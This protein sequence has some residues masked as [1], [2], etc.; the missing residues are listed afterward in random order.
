MAAMEG[1]PFGSGVIIGIISLAALLFT[2][3]RL[4]QKK[5][6]YPLPPGPR[7]EPILGH[8]RTVPVERPEL[9]YEQLAKEYSE[10]LSL[11]PS[12]PQDTNHTFFADTDIL[13]FRQLRTPV[14]VLNTV[15]AAEEL[16]SKRGANFSDRPRFVLFEV[17][18][19][20]GVEITQQ[21]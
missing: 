18:V 7:G 12:E 21:G 11:P 3:A 4:I 10:C 6:P 16:L 8:I 5:S 15:K 2:A 20:P 19:E 13:Y 14:I 17:F 1:Y 9:Y